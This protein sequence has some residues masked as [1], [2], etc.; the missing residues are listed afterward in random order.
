MISSIQTRISMENRRSLGHSRG[1]SSS[2]RDGFLRAYDEEEAAGFGL[3]DLAEDSD[4]DVD[5][6]SP[7]IGNHANGSA[8][9]NGKGFEPIELQARKVNGDR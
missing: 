5:P 2:D 1:H 7:M 8:N 9:G 3:T 6:R 4:E